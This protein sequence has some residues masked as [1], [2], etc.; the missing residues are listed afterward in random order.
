MANILIGGSV[1][2]MDNA[3]LRMFELFHPFWC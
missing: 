3:S 2:G 1:E